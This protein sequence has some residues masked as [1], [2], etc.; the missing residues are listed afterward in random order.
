MPGQA[1]LVTITS[2]T[3]AFRPHPILT[4]S[5]KSHLL[6]PWSFAGLGAMSE[7][8]VVNPQRAGRSLQRNIF[9]GGGVGVT[10]TNLE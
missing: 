6:R 9:D 10:P 3:A 7:G 8:E 2:H 1:V 4:Q 5:L